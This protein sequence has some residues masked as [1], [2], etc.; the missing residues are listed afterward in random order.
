MDDKLKKIVDE[1][2]QK[3]EQ[4]SKEYME[5]DKETADYFLTLGKADSL[6]EAIELIESNYK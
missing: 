3:W 5:M 2:T 4:L 6:G 1:L